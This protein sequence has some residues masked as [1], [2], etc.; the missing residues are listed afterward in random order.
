M[1]QTVSPPSQILRDQATRPKIDNS[2]H[3]INSIKQWLSQLVVLGYH[4]EQK[5]ALLTLIAARQP[6]SS[7]AS[8]S[9]RSF[10][11]TLRNSVR[12]LRDEGHN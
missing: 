11:G 2:H 1:V 6:V 3:Y 4:E 9:L 7:D 10:I 12:K 8:T 5:N